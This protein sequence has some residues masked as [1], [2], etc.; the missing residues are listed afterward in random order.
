MSFH[1]HDDDLQVSVTT[2]ANDITAA[3]Y[4]LNHKLAVLGVNRTD[5]DKS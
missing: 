2:A 5:V 4:R 3:T 1:L